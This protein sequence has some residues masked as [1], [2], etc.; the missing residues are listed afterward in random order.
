[1]KLSGWDVAAQKQK[2]CLKR[3]EHISSL[4]NTKKIRRKCL[5]FVRGC[6]WDSILSYVTFCFSIL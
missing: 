5:I 3:D 4:V 6:L 1:M 2:G